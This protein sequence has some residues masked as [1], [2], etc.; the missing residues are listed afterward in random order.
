MKGSINL[1]R[2]AVEATPEVR[3]GYRTGLKA[4]ERTDASKVEVSDSRKI[5]GSLD[6]DGAT[7]EARPDEARWDYAIGY[8]SRIYFMEVHPACTG[9]IPEI[10]KKLTWIKNWLN[11]PDNKLNVLQKGSPLFSWI[12]TDA[13][14]H[15]PAVSSQYKKLASK[16]LLPKRKLVLH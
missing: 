8:N 14:V 10:I 7:K 5:D 12:A 1:F 13:G 16:G 9:N 4:M 2:Q 15:I 6:I 11:T 3:N